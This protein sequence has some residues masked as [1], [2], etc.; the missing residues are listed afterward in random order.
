MSASVKPSARPRHWTPSPRLPEPLP[1]PA[2]TISFWALHT[3]AASCKPS[4]RHNSELQGQSSLSAF[5]QSHCLGI[6]PSEQSPIPETRHDSFPHPQPSQPK[7]Q[8]TSL[9]GSWGCVFISPGHITRAQSHV[10]CR[11]IL[12]KNNPSVFQSDCQS[13]Q[14][15][16]GSDGSTSSQTLPLPVL[17]I[18]AT[19]T[20]VRWNHT[21]VLIHVCE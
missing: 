5:T 6:L 8:P 2:A 3:D 12:L 21:V 17:F 9:T 7:L 16:T 10:P 4:V 15:D 18:L 19:L 13:H 1:T 20:S 14:H 11:L